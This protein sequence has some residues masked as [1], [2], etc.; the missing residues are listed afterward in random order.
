M[1]QYW[2]RVW[3]DQ[4]SLPSDERATTAL[5]ASGLA[6]WVQ[7]REEYPAIRDYLP[8][9]PRGSR[10]LDGGSGLGKWVLW[11]KS[12]GYAAVGLD[13]SQETVDRLNE[14]FPGK[15]FIRGDIQK[16]GFPDGHFDA[17]TSW[18]TFEHF[19]EGLG[20]C[21]REG[22]RILKPGG[23]LFVS[24]P[25]QNR[26]FIRKSLRP[27]ARWDLRY[28]LISV[29]TTPVRFHQWR[30]TESELH[31]EFVLHGFEMLSIR[32][33]HQ[34]SGLHWM[35]AEDFRLPRGSIGHKIAYTICKPFLPA[36][37]VA[38]MLLGVGRKR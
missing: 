22:A 27:L 12:L 3:R 33:I 13:I 6:E 36:R 24:V 11:W 32:P 31:H 37:Y 14:I 21:F 15:L 28:D 1:D 5:L 34:R 29:H 35:L 8:V 17:Y 7:K 16:T 25:F 4:G 30:L 18:G 38:H 19:E 26:R 9:I 23:L 10:V 20:N 2:T